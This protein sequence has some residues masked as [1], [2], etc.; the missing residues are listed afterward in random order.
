MAGGNDAGV[1]KNLLNYHNSF[2]ASNGKPNLARNSTLENG[3]YKLIQ[4][5]GSRNSWAHSHD[6]IGQGNHCRDYN[7]KGFAWHATKYVPSAYG[8]NLGYGYDTSLEVFREWKASSAHR[9]NM[10][11]RSFRKV[12]FAYYKSTRRGRYWIALFGY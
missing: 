4:Q 10:L 2:R 11:N 1:L 7:H 5:M 3:A 12:G 6:S 8:E 9:P